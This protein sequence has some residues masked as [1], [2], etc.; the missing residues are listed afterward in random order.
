MAYVITR[1][2]EGV[3]DAACVSVCP[4]DCI[5]GPVPLAELEAVPQSERAARFGAI[6]LYIDPEDCLDCGA[7]LPVC[8]VEAIYPEDDLPPEHAEDAARNAAFFGR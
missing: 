8:P 1:P 7:C 4:V 3:C 5:A 2:C 6:Q